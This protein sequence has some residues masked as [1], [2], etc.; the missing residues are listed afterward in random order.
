MYSSGRIAWESPYIGIKNQGWF[1][2][3]NVVTDGAASHTKYPII[4]SSYV[5]IGFGLEDNA[6][7]TVFQY[8]QEGQI[9]SQS[10]A[11]QWL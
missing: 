7:Q 8:S 2:E 6:P 9:C 4:S 1:F 3:S 5:N 10:G 11:E